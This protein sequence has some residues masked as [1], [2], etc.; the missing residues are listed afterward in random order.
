LS[1]AFALGLFAWL[2]PTHELPWPS[3]HAEFAASLAG[4]LA[5]GVTLWHHGRRPTGFPAIAFLALLAAAIVLAQLLGGVIV[6]GGDAALAGLYLLGFALAVVVGHAARVGGSHEAGLGALAWL[7][8]LGALA[9]CWLALYQWQHLDYLGVFAGDLDAGSRVF[10]NLNQP[11]HLATLLVLGLLATAGLFD[12]SRLGTAC[13]A[14]LVVVFGFCLAMTQSRV[15]VLE[16]V[17]A[18]V[19]LLGKRRSLGQR[20]T[21]R[22]LLVALAVVLAMPVVWEAVNALYGLDPGRGTAEAAAASSRRLVHWSSMVDAIGRRPWVGYG[23][24]QT[25]IAQFAVAPDHP[26]TFEPFGYSHNLAIDL[27]VWNGLPLG[28]AMIAGLGWWF[29]A[30]TRGARRS[31][32]VLALAAIVAVLVHAMLEFPLHYAYF[33]LPTGYLMGAVSA[34]TIPDAEVKAPAWVGSVLLGTA[35]LMLAVITSDYLGFARDVD[36]LRFE[37]ARIGIDRPK[38]ELSNPMLLSQLGAFA[39][40]A[41]TPE[42]KGITEVEL[43]AMEQVSK[44]FPS[45]DNLVRFAAAM[46]L[47]DRPDRAAQALRRICKT[48]A[49]SIC[50]ASKARWV[51]LGALQPS[52]ATIDWP[53]Q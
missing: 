9:S 1:A 24:N 3:F 10:A 18:G 31:D 42:R 15:G 32:E 50:E 11:N 6:F 46:A 48:H 17:A 44:R 13:A 2:T 39:F 27:L 21:L 12:A 43:Q 14:L 36:S 16:I 51:A 5:G 35:G 33:L 7:L 45:A 22:H 37:R 26:A 40:F 38:R 8:L 49:P 34:T 41:R 53:R 25:S 30:S 29:W 52:I 23:W 47:N 28:L 4:L 20:L 19:L